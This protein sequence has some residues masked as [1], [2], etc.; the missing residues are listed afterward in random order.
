MS[1]NTV[2][3]NWMPVISWA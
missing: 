2:C 1:I 3:Y